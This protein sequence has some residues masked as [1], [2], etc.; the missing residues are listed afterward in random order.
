MSKFSTQV[1]IWF[2]P[3][4]DQALT[5]R[6]ASRPAL[7]RETSLQVLGL[8]P[9]VIFFLSR[10]KIIRRRPY[11]S[12]PITSAALAPVLLIFWTLLDSQCISWDSTATIFSNFPFCCPLIQP[13]EWLKLFLIWFIHL[14]K[15]VCSSASNDFHSYSASSLLLL[16]ITSP[17]SSLTGPHSSA[18][19]DSLATTAEV[20]PDRWVGCCFYI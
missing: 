9:R 14:F 20:E 3:R 12:L 2:R 6:A 11:L 18:T 1:K 19:G 4:L 5:Q 7:N 8:L 17:A 13:V 15:N 16:I 10:F